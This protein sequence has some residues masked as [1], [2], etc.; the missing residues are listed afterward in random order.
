MHH[1][2]ILTLNEMKGKNLIHNE[3]R[4]SR[5]SG[6]P[7]ASQHIKGHAMKQDA[8]GETSRF[9]PYAGLSD[10]ID[11]LA[12]VGVTKSRLGLGQVFVLG[13]IAASY[14]SFATTLSIVAGAGIQTPG[15]QKLVMGLVFPIGLISLVIGGGGSGE[16]HR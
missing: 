4:H 7:E 12:T 3:F 10:T 1:N 9:V 8:Q 6:N 13:F 11:E 15:L 14:L 5:E 16:R 2:V